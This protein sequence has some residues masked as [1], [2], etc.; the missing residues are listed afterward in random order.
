[1]DLGIS[2]RV[3]LVTGASKG[4]GRGIAAALA[5]EGA[6]VAVTSRSRERI[7]EAAREVGAAAAFAH[8]S[9]DL[10]AVPKLVDAVESEL[11]P[12]EILITNT[13][14]PPR[15]EPLGADRETWERALSRPRSWRR[16]R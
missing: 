11:G 8:D 16:W 9:S 5:A 12:V 3:A 10:D 2:D 15:G 7:D 6:R 14:G 4:L 1:M 13:G